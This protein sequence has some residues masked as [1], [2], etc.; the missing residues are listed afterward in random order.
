MLVLLY[1]VSKSDIWATVLDYKDWTNL[2]RLDLGII[3]VYVEQC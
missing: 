2:K 3:F 1:S